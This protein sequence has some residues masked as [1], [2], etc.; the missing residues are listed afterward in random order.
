[1]SEL[2]TLVVAL[3]ALIGACSGV[4]AAYH[5]KQTHR[6]VNHQRDVMLSLI[7]KQEQTIRAFEDAAIRR[8][9]S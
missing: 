1:M 5:A 6:I 2:A 4:Y 8:E 7:A 9:K 3:S